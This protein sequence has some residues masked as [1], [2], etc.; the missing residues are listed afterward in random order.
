MGGQIAGQKHWRA[1]TSRNVWAT[2]TEHR[3]AARCTRRDQTTDYTES[4]ITDCT[5]GSAR[6][7]AIGLCRGQGWRRLVTDLPKPVPIVPCISSSA[8]LL[9]IENVPLATARWMS[10]PLVVTR[11]RSSGRHAW[12]RTVHRQPSFQH[13]A[14]FCLHPPRHV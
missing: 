14:T 12:K 2:D 7:R 1:P 11:G 10:I 13:R 8:L 9:G 6:E 5:D 4:Q 3:A